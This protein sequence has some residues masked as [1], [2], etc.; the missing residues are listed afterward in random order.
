MP[1]APNKT[2]RSNSESGAHVKRIEA[3][4]TDL[5]HK[6]KVYYIR[7]PRRVVVLLTA[8]LIAPWIV[9]LIVTMSS[10]EHVARVG[11]PSG[12][13]AVADTSFQI[14]SPGPWGV[15]ERTRIF[16]QPPDEFLSPDLLLQTPAQWVLPECTSKDAAS[17]FLRKAGVDSTLCATLSTGAEFNAQQRSCILHPTPDQ[18][19]SLAPDTRASLYTALA[20]CPAN[21][22]QRDPFVFHPSLINEWLDKE[23]L[24]PA[25]VA[26]VKQLLYPNKQL[27]LLSDYNLLG[28]RVS[29]VQEKVRLCSVLFRRESL[30]VRLC[31]FG[32]NDTKSMINYWGTG[33]RS[34]EVAPL[35]E[36]MEHGEKPL[37]VNITLLLT[38][39]AREKLYTFPLPDNS[40]GVAARDCH[41]SSM[42]FFNI[43]PDERFGNANYVR[44]VIQ[45][46]YYR[47]PGQPTFG[48]VTLFATP[49]GTVVHS[50]VYIA[51]GIY[52]TRNGPSYYSPW[53]LLSEDELIE[54]FPMY[55][56]AIS[57]YR[58]KKL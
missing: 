21:K 52:F 13:A 11:V 2:T 47:V 20:T 1:T 14:G 51:D 33:G 58:P 32:Q 9:V 12:G 34:V 50:A 24:Q 22:V 41:W 55:N 29:D 28:A 42:N 16:L 53:M 18:V 49:D 56:L 35:I 15:L 3:A 26:L 46:D 10:R 8:L 4:L 27:L 6:S 54:A 44:E 7:L 23:G 30:M 57:H 36:A 45:K 25:T 31:G 39:F 38:H 17:E 43:V 5:E 40:P 48:D 19:L 37:S